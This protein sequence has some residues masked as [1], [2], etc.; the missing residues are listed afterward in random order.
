M[1]FYLYE[2]VHGNKLANSFGYMQTY[3]VVR[4]YLWIIWTPHTSIPYIHI[5]IHGCWLKVQCIPF[6][7]LSDAHK[8]RHINDWVQIGNSLLMHTISITHTARQQISMSMIF[9]CWHW[10]CHGTATDSHSQ[11]F[12]FY[13]LI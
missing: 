2:R 6:I 4:I 9:K 8:F 13:R 11:P 5:Q 3:V 10:H 1:W 7:G 12:I